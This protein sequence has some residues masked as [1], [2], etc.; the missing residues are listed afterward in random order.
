VRRQ[1]SLLCLL[2]L[3]GC[4][5]YTLPLTEPAPKVAPQ[6]SIPEPSERRVGAWYAFTDTGFFY[7]FKRLF[8]L[9]LRVRRALGRQERALDIDPWGEVIDSKWFTNRN[10][11][12]PL[13]PEEM[14]RGPSPP[15]AE[16][17]WTVTS[18][19]RGGIQPGF[20]MKDAAGKKFIV[21]LDAAAYPEMAT[22]AEVVAERFYFAAGYNVPGA[23][24]IYFR[25]ER[26]TIA[27]GAKYVDP[28][29]FTRPL[30]PEALADIL[31][32]APQRL[33]G[34]VRAVAV[35]YVPGRLKGPFSFLGTRGDD[36]NDTI[37]HQDRRS[38]RALLVISSFLN[39]PDLIETNTLDA[40]VSEGGKSYLEHYLI[41]FGTSLGSYAFA[42]KPRRSGHEHAIDWA[43]IGQSLFSLGRYRRPYEGQPREVRPGVGYLDMDL[44]EPGRWKSEYPNPAFDRLSPEDGLW[45]ARVVMSF[46]DGQIRAAVRSARL[47]D[48][49]AEDYLV[50]SLLVRRDSVGRYWFAQVSPLVGF[51]VSGQGLSFRDLAVECGLAPP[52][53][54]E[55]RLDE[56]TLRLPVGATTLP[57]NEPAGLRERAE[58]ELE[59]RAL[60]PGWEPLPPVR[61]RLA[62]E[63]VG[64]RVLGLRHEGR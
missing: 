8:D 9:P 3:G 63:A 11:A 52:S 14:E 32:Q 26:L 34:L 29:G 44:F 23:S 10:L 30:T 13:S 16:G 47:S 28:D 64:L 61:V 31:A 38:L 6:A 18:G 57:L 45:G 36:P 24:I 62:R 46:T 40:Y 4:A 58:L 19:K 33:G 39:N 35:S 54:Y 60:R 21:K 27:E 12:R 56:A 5:Y 7:P 17:D 2:L 22:A 1:V 20:E 55:V 51:A 49:A 59:V 41:D 15:P 43:E 37:P 53:A 42:P 48:P 25:P 50:R